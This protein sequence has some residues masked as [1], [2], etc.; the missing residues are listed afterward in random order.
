[1]GIAILHNIAQLDWAAIEPAIFGTLFT[2]SLDPTQRAKLGAQYTSKDDI[3]LI[4]E[5]VLMAPLRR[6]WA[7]I[8]EQAQELGAA[9][10]DG[11]DAGSG[12][13]GAERAEQ[14]DPG[15]CAEAGNCSSS[16]SGVWQRQFPLCLAA[17]AAGFVEGSVDFCRAGGAV[18]AHAA[19]GAGAVAAAAVRDR[20]Q[21]LCARAGAGDGVDRVFAVAAR[22]WVWVYGGADP[23]AAGQYQADG[24]DF[25]L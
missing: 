3:L 11:A 9:A 21:R 1:M 22:E 10:G 17:P 15:L 18:D 13:A 6:E 20:D 12:H 23:E 4:V 7:E 25:G 2:R 16:G 5:P 24:C 19:A 14:S 8:K